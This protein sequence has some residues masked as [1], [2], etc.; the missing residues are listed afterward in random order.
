MPF[1]KSLSALLPVVQAPLRTAL[2]IAP[3]RLLAPVLA[4]LFTHLVRGQALQGRLAT[5]A[6]KR[7]SLLIMDLPCELR[8]RIT[9][10]GLADGWSSH[11]QQPWDVRIRG[12]YA[13][14]WLMATRAEDPD[15]LFFNR[16]LAIE[17]DTETGLTLKNLLDA[18]EYDWRAH[19]EAVLGPLS[20]LLPMR[21]ESTDLP[22]RRRFLR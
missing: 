18:L 20:A 12:T 2:R 5:L 22:P 1:P 21:R 8:F 19:V 16:R 7:V 4:A 3:E 6:G 17:G 15:T 14:F 10:R 9:D 13:D 11:G